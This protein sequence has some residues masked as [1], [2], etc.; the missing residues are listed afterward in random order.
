MSSSPEAAPTSPGAIVSISPAEVF[1]GDMSGQADTRRL[2]RRRPFELTRNQA[3]ELYDAIFSQT[4]EL[5][6]TDNL[7]LAADR[8][9]PPKSIGQY[10]LVPTLSRDPHELQ[11]SMGAVCARIT[12]RADV[13]FEYDRPS[14]D[15]YLDAQI[16]LTLTYNNR[17]VA[18]CA[19]GLSKSGPFIRQ[20][21]DISRAM[22][23]QEDPKSYLYSS[24]LRAGFMWRDTLIT[25]WQTM[26]S[27]ALAE[28]LPDFANYPTSVQSAR[29]NDWIYSY[30]KDY[31][32][33]IYQV[34]DSQ[35]LERQRRNY[36]QTAIRLGGQPDHPKGDYVLPKEKHD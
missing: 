20:V 23:E 18:I 28:T 31:R 17:G 33:D 16:G 3:F 27:T 9:K 13:A 34:V 36:D 7:V 6:L 12:T 8:T 30:V 1:Y 19:G 4:D 5:A 21:Q 14:N 24:G 26:V 10:N 22:Q 35:K 25:A 2:V 29:N 32:N 11:R 15:P